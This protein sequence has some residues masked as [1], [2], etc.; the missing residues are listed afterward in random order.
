MLPQLLKWGDVVNII[1]IDVSY[2]DSHATL[3]AVE[4]GK[5]WFRCMRHKSGFKYD[6]NFETTGVIQHN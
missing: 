6:N 5:I 3:I 2:G 4:R 1:G